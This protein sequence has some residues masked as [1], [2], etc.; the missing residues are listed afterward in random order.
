[1]YDPKLYLNEIWPP[2]IQS[3]IYYKLFQKGSKV[4]IELLYQTELY[5]KTCE[6][7]L[8]SLVLQ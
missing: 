2:K 5:L 7:D 6:L 4:K 1:M 3:E 8:K